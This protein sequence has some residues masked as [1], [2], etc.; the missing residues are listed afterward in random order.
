MLTDPLDPSNPWNT[1]NP[2]NPTNPSDYLF[3]LFLSVLSVFICFKLSLSVRM[4]FLSVFISFYLLYLFCFFLLLFYLFFCFVCLYVSPILSVSICLICHR[5][6]QTG[7]GTGIGIGLGWKSLNA[8]I[9]RAPFFG[10]YNIK[11]DEIWCL[12]NG[13]YSLKNCH[14]PTRSD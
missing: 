8:L 9:L 10:A 4:C 7:T 6:P 13:L 5:L 3:C 14:N 11:Y 12:C 1:I 2:T